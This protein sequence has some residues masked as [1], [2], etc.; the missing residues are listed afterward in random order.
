MS[1]SV[2]TLDLHRQKQKYLHRPEKDEIGDCYRT[3]IACVL[4]VP[5]DSVPHFVEIYGWDNGDEVYV[6]LLDWLKREHGMNV[7]R[8]PIYSFDRG[9]EHALATIQ[10]W[11]PTAGRFL[12]SGT[13]RNGTMHCVVAH[14]GE[15]EWD[16]AIDN[17]GIVG[18]GPG[19]WYW[20]EFIVGGAA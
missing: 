20:A 6:A 18:P 10:A 4:G 15:I 16:P 5:R 17:S 2:M 14:A 13:S 12:F 3:A 8:F 9:H 1:A 7:V 19:G 11:N